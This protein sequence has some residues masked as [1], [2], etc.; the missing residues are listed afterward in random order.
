[1]HPTRV[2]Y[3]TYVVT[4]PIQ[5]PVLRTLLAPHRHAT[6]ISYVDHVRGIDTS[7]PQVGVW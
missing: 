6:V 4:E 5:G 3:T 1:M 2:L 7:P